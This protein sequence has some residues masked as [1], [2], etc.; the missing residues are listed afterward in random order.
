[1]KAP[2][3]KLIMRIP[4]GSDRTDSGIF[5]AVTDAKPQEGEVLSSGRR[6][7][8]AKGCNWWGFVDNGY[9]PGNHLLFSRFDNEEIDNGSLSVPLSNVYARLK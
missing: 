7:E 8:R 1:M 4:E 6:W 2:T 9:Q 5:L 3:N